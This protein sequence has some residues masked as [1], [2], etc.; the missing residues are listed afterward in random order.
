[1]TDTFWYVQVPDG[2]E[3]MDG[4]ISEENMVET[5]SCGQVSSEER[6]LSRASKK[7]LTNGLLLIGGVIC[8]SRGHSSLGAK[9][10]M[11]YILTKLSKRVD[12]PQGQMASVEQ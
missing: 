9:V 1:M 8:L 3:D 10:V 11:A 2:F 5:E 4:I 6:K 12:A 7:L